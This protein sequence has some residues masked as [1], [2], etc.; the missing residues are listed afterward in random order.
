MKFRVNSIF[1][2]G[3]VLMLIF[4]VAYLA[5]SWM[6][7]LN[8]PLLTL[9]KPSYIF[10][11]TPGSSLNKVAYDLQKKGILEHPSYLVLLGYIKHESRKIKAGEYL[12]Q[13]DMKP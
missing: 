8:K 11:V 4:I 10:I 7:F 13:K 2:T 1:L 12:F 3:F 9:N 6:Q 5:I